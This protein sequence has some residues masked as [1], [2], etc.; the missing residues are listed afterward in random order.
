MKDGKRMIP[1]YT[2]IVFHIQSFSLKH[3]VLKA[4]GPKQ[5]QNLHYIWSDAVAVEK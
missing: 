1:K 4:C 5:K 3:S 2:L